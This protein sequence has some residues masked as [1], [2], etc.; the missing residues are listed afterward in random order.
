MNV[1]L[2]SQQPPSRLLSLS[3]SLSLPS[4]TATP[5]LTPSRSL[6]SL[7]SFFVLFLPLCLYIPYRPH[8][9]GP[10]LSLPHSP[11]AP[12]ENLALAAPTRGPI[13]Y[14]LSHI[15]DNASQH[16]I[17]PASASISIE[18]QWLV[19]RRPFHPRS[20]PSLSSAARAD[21]ASAS[22][23]QDDGPSKPASAL[24]PPPLPLVAV[25]RMAVAA[26]AV[27]IARSLWAG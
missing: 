25:C 6:S 4:P 8:S 19:K 21:V 24:H 15:P 7:F 5:V 18:C 11:T 14:R 23:D 16:P 26:M 3:L 1:V 12:C 2:F 22:H 13:R 10:S 9:L 27:R 17:L 20:R